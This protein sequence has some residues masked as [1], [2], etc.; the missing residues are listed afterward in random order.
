MIRLSSFEF[1]GLAQHL[2]EHVRDFL[3]PPCQ[4]GARLA[5]QGPLLFLPVLLPLWNAATVEPFEMGY[6]LCRLLAA[7]SFCLIIGFQPCHEDGMLSCSDMCLLYTRNQAKQRI[8]YGNMPCVCVIQSKRERIEPRNTSSL[9]QIDRVVFFPAF[10]SPVIF[11]LSMPGSFRLYF[12]QRFLIFCSEV[13]ATTKSPTCCFFLMR[14][15]SVDGC[16]CAWTS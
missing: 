9:C 3:E 14:R 10:F 7:C 15:S 12:R 8:H 1:L 4:S 11:L 16:S 5:N 6:F 13:K 2:S